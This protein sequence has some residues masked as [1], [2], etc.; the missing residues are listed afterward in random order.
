MSLG[1]VKANAKL[2]L[3]HVLNSHKEKRRILRTAAMREKL[4]LKPQGRSKLRA[5][6]HAQAGIARRSISSSATQFSCSDVIKTVEQ[7][8]KIP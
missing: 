6:I 4:L 7:I 1:V 5:N 2:G 8:D 3:I